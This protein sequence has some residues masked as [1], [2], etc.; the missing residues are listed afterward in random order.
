MQGRQ[1]PS[2][3]SGGQSASLSLHQIMSR[4]LSL[5]LESRQDPACDIVYLE[6]VKSNAAS[7]NIGMVLFCDECGLRVM[8]MGL[9][10]SCANIFWC[11]S[12]VRWVSY[13]RSLQQ[14]RWE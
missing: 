3:S 2:T 7:N 14:H 10:L 9:L 1:G 12:G 13:N 8:M 11:V 4:P 6:R 5:D